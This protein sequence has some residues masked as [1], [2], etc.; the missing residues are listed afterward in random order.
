MSQPP[1]TWQC[2]TCREWEQSNTPALGHI[3]QPQ[4]ERLWFS[5]EMETPH[6]LFYEPFRSVTCSCA[7][8]IS[9]PGSMMSS[10]NIL[11]TSERNNRRKLPCLH[12]CRAALQWDVN[13]SLYQKENAEKM[14]Y[15]MSKSS[16]RDAVQT[17]KVPFRSET[18]LCLRWV[19]CWRVFCLNQ[20]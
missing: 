4:D 18:H 7:P 5:D 10:Q 3:C 6:P 20:L 13:I 15:W 19:K 9:H 11:F 14:H 16:N 12:R 8:S 1:W 2:S 17:R